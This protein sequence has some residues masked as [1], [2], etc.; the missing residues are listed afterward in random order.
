MSVVLK[1]TAYPTPP[2]A[3]SNPVPLNIEPIS[4]SQ[5]SRYVGTG[6][7]LEIA[8]WY[9]ERGWDVE[10]DS[11]PSFVNYPFFLYASRLDNEGNLVDRFVSLVGGDDTTVMKAKENVVAFSRRKNVDLWVV[12]SVNR[13]NKNV[14]LVY[15]IVRWF[16]SNKH[17]DQRE[18]VIF[19]VLT[20]E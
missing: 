15:E 20:E 5:I 16:F 18:T 11:N 9:Y 3:K 14:P 17:W 2:G 10:N 1:Q 7:F 12:K 8:K 13:K 4:S 6:I 19:R